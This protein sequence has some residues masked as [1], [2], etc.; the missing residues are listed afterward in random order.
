MFQ[1][2][3]PPGEWS[4]AMS[5]TVATTLSTTMT[6][7]NHR[8]RVSSLTPLCETIQ[9]ARSSATVEPCSHASS[10]A[11]TT[12]LKIKIRFGAAANVQI[13]TA[14]NS[15]DN[16]DDDA[17]EED[18]EE[19]DESSV[20][21]TSTT[22]GSP[23]AEAAGRIYYRRLPPLQPL[24]T[25][26]LKSGPNADQHH[27]RHHQQQQEKIPRELVAQGSSSMTKPASPSL[28]T[29]KSPPLVSTSGSLLGSH[30]CKQTVTSSGG[31][32]TSSGHLPPSLLLAV[33]DPM[34]GKQESSTPFR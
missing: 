26:S 10:S 30:V 17:N 14:V 21:T 28:L 12:G 2:G 32:T 4:R 23:Y 8:A 24:P 3:E 16:D 18:E 20:S 15:D 7:S 34:N 19:D 25:V 13:P 1:H 31:S 11:S 9:P 29:L 5:S 33:K 22:P 27:H 6:A